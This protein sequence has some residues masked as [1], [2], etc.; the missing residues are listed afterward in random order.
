MPD[1]ILYPVRAC[2]KCGN[3]FSTK[4]CGACNRAYMLEY[5]KK[6]KD[7]KKAYC[8]SN[9]EQISEYKKK[10]NAEHA[11]AIKAASAAYREKN[12][13]KV[14]ATKRAYY[15]ANHIEIK[16]KASSRHFENKSANNAR[17]SKYHSE[18]RVLVRE[19]QSLYYAK[20]AKRLRENAS[21]WASNHS[22]KVKQRMAVWRA[23]NP[24]TGR[25]NRQN[26][27]DRINGR[28][29]SVGIVAKLFKLQKG[30]CV[31]CKAPLGLGYHLDH[32]MPLALGGLNVDENTQL[33]TA[34]CNLKK[35]A[36][37]P[38]DFMQ[39]RGFLL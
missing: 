13:E 10:Y 1:Q 11:E 15:D 26:R 20:N 21:K 38:V 28:K 3:L 12:P 2:V 24:H 9:A 6:N 5:S 33:L 36:K 17:S 4:N 39:E 27:R 7:K 8:I 25:I 34:K 32:I 37:H 19:R 16:K 18:N 22:E 31:C 23:K 14:R 29:L 30:L 35:H